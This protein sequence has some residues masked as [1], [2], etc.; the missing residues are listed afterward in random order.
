MA[1]NGH[2]P[3]VGT[4]TVKQ[5]L[6][7]M[8]KGGVIVSLR[9]DSWIGLDWIIFICGCGGYICVFHMDD[10]IWMIFIFML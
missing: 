8:L 9:K 4:A 7:Q 10:F 2:T 3:K 5:G 6:A 1:T